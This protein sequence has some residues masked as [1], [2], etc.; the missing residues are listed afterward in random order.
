MKIYSPSLFIEIDNSEYIF[1]VGDIDEKENF[2]LIYEHKVLLRGIENFKIT[3]LDLILKD[4][5]TNIYLIEQKLNFTFK[6]T[7]LIINNFSRYFIN[8]TGFKKLNGSQILKENITYILNSLKSN[9]NKI[10][11]KKKLIHIFNSSFCLDKKNTENL[12]IGLFGD[13]YSHE[14]S[15]C[16]INKND[17]K[18]LKNIIENCN[19]KIKKILFK[20]FAV[21]S[22]LSNIKENNDTFIHIK[23]NNNN[24]QV[25]SFENNSLKFE[26]NFSFGFDQ[27]IK[28]ISKITFLKEDVVKNIISSGKLSEQTSRNDLIEK[29]FFVNEN[30]RNIKKKTIYDIAEA[31]IEELLEIILIK[32]IN[33][34]KHKQKVFF[35][36]INNKQHLECFKNSYISIF[37]KNSLPT[38]K[39]IE[40]IVAKDFIKNVHNLVSFGWKREAIPVT[41]EKK[42]SIARL[43]DV[44][45]D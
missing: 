6:E 1:T 13:F 35:I 45:F 26:Q 34:S 9:V 32:N 36:N 25:F 30:Y 24:S 15:F 21:G 18:N 19:L 28:D 20:S 11:D 27:V 42:T 33:L 43:F 39:L 44:L 12:P 2:N 22:Y 41:H 14:L 37:L 7:V 40:N 10:E 29:K 5:R 4:V 23:I 17:Y 31:R 38:P 3:S 8:F 16:L